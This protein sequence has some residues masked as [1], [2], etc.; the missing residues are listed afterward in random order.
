MMT[1]QQVRR[2]LLTWVEGEMDESQWLKLAQHLETCERCRAE[3]QQ[4]QRLIATLRGI[5]QSDGIPPVP[6]RL[7]NRLT[8][9]RRKL[10]AIVSLFMTACTA[11]LLGWSVRG[12]AMPSDPPKTTTVM[13]RGVRDEG[14]ERMGVQ[15]CKHASVQES[16]RTSERGFGLSLWTDTALPSQ[17]SSPLHV[18]FVSISSGNDFDRLSPSPLSRMRFESPLAL[19]G[20]TAMAFG[21][22]RE[23]SL[24]LPSPNSRF[25]SNSTMDEFALDNVGTTEWDEDAYQVADE[26]PYRIF[27]QVT[28]LKE[29]V[30]RTVLVDRREP[31]HVVAEW[32]EQRLESESAT[33]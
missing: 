28:D 3:V 22:Q 12:I 23:H 10:P 24:Y 27:V 17:P 16:K 2:N 4:W 20:A 21:I 11:F 18:R 14:R 5:A 25:A 1:C 9:R 13:G 33:H 6:P 19:N 15:E 8:V 31:S 26:P 29:Q 7:W 30:V 32:S